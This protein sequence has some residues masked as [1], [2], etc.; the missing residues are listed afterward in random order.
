MS[1]PLHFN[2]LKDEERKSSSPVR[3]QVMAP[4]LSL[5]AVIGLLLWW[6]MTA[7]KMS[8]LEHERDTLTEEITTAQQSHKDVIRLK[9]QSL[10]IKASLQQLGFFKT[11]RQ[12]WGETLAKIATAVPPDI[13][14]TSLS[15]PAPKPPPPDPKTHAVPAPTNTS[16]AVQLEIRG[17]AGGEHPAEAVNT[18]LKALQSGAFT[19]RIAS[20]TVPKGSIRQDVTRRDVLLFEIMCECRERRFQ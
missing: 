9:T 11:S 18:L 12:Q 7:A 10:D 8:T 14:L 4:V 5:I 2:L 20:A 13:Q 3:M 6:A 19:N 1:A 15:I 17:Y 16:E